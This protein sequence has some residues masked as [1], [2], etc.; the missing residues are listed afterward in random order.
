M[1][2]PAGTTVD[3]RSAQLDR[4]RDKAAAAATD[5]EKA[6]AGVTELDNR[7]ATN[8]SMINQ[9]KQALRNTAAEAG[10]LKRSIKAAARERDRLAKARKKAVARAEKAQARSKSAEAKYDKSVLAVMVRREK[11]KDRAAAGDESAAAPP[12]V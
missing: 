3:Q 12:A 9:Q 5:A 10:R 11:A 4:R 1:T 6:Q 2:A 7:L 8:A